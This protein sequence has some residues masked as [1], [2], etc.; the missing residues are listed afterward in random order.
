[1]GLIVQ[2]VVVIA[3]E[4]FHVVPHAL[5]SMDKQNVTILDIQVMVV[6]MVDHLVRGQ[7][8]N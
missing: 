4:V 5:D 2:Q 6:R 8:V 1:M 7:L 3:M